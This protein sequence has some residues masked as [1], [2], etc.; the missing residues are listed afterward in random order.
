MFNKD[1]MNLFITDGM[2]NLNIVK[3]I[4]LFAIV[5]Y[6][7]YLYAYYIIGLKLFN[8]GIDVE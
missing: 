3:L 2:I 8:K 1:V 6:G 7:I 5:L 4:M